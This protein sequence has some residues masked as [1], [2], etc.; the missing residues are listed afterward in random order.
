MGE[1]LKAGDV[2]YLKSDDNI[3]MTINEIYEH[4]VGECECIWFA[5]TDCHRANFNLDAL[6]KA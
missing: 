5:G 1:K 6:K 3:K 2:V 4:N